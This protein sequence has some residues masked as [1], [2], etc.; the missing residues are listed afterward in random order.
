MFASLNNINI[1]LNLFKY[2]FSKEAD[3]MTLIKTSFYTSISQFLTIIAGLIGVKV[4][5]SKIGPEGIAMT[6][7]FFNTT[8]ILSLFATGAISTAI[9]KYLAEYKDDKV[10]QLKIIRAAFVIMLSCSII[11]GLSV[12]LA[13]NYL[14]KQLFKTDAYSVVYVLWGT[15]LVITSLSG[16]F[17]SVLN[18][19]KLI[20]YLTIV[21]ITGTVAGLIITIVLAQFYG[22]YGVLVAVNFT[23]LVLLL[24][25][26]YFLN[27]YK[28]FAFKD[29]FGY[30]DRGV[31]RLF[32]GFIVMTLASGILVPA[33]QL[34]V[35]DKIVRDFSFQDAGYWQSVTRISDYYLGFITSVL[36]IYY[37]PR[38][39]EIKEKHELH[40]E[41]KQG[42][43][44]I[45]PIVAGLSL[46][47]WLF[48]FFIIKLLF[49]NEFL[50]SETLYGFQ[51]LGDF[52]KIA[53]WLLAYLMLARGMKVIFI[54]SEIAY[55]LIYVGLCF[56]FINKFGLIGAVYGFCASYFMYLIGMYIVMSKKQ[57][58]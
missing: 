17:G 10:M 36:A 42:Y 55:S 8:A 25:H 24:L 58:I 43:K 52:F 29:L 19:L 15:F 23:S 4:V 7:Q 38:L 32:S 48:R 14:S 49:T 5:A 12:I 34:L 56:L 27:K 50:P 39:S 2:K 44:I 13:S 28:W 53:S 9:V 33:I 21:N 35:R 18:G 47:I 3:Y 37:L 16:L 11:I 57:I 54:V 41:I 45:L 20:S 26:I 51:F 22:V 30:I 1:L 6:G 40:L 46:L 31:F